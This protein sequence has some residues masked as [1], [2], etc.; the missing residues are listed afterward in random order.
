[1]AID[2]R[3]PVGGDDDLAVGAV[4]RVERV[5]ELLLEALLVLHELDVVDEQHVALAV[6]ALEG[7]GGVGAD[8]VDELVHERL[9]GH[10]AHVPAGKFSRT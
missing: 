4:E 8:G 3:R 7:G 5:E 1:M 9:G 6:A 2:S 10:V